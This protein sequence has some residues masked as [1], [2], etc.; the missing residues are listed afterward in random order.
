MYWTILAG[1]LGVLTSFFFYVIAED[2]GFRQELTRAEQAALA[3][4]QTITK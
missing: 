2:W 1:V 4:G 3:Q